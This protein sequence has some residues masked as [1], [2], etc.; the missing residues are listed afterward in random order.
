MAGMAISVGQE[1]VIRKGEVMR[2]PI[3]VGEDRETTS[4]TWRVLITI[5]GMS[6]ISRHLDEAWIS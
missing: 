1:G 4:L 6:E 3:S 2:Y 5:F